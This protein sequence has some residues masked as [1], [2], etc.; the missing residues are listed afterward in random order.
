MQRGFKRKRDDVSGDSQNS[1]DAESP[2]SL[3]S[4]GVSPGGSRS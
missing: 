2:A 3:K 1:E 4:G